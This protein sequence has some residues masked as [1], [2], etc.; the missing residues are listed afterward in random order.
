MINNPLIGLTLSILFVLAFLIVN[1]LFLLILFKRFYNSLPR[2][3]I[4]N[5]ISNF[6]IINKT[7]RTSNKMPLS[8]KLVKQILRGI[9]TMLIGAFFLLILNFIILLVVILL[10]LFQ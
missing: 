6:L 8:N 7:V 3:T 9:C 2:L 5:L 1:Y 4:K 10:T